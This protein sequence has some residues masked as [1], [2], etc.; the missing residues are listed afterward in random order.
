M[1]TLTQNSSTSA[2]SRWLHKVAVVLSAMVLAAT[3]QAAEVALLDQNYVLF[4]SD[5]AQAA[6]A[7]L[8]QE[9]AQEEQQVQ[10]LGQSIQQLQSRARTDADI[11]TDAEMS[12]LEAQ[13]QQRARQREQLVRQLQQVQGE[14]RSAFV[15]QFQ[16]LMAE[17][18][19]AVVEGREFDIILDKAA[20]V[21]HR[22]SLDLTDAVLEQFNAL[23]QAQ[24]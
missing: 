2:G 1:K 18:I 21:Y 7:E 22:N 3:V 5:A 16:P 4:N 17:A 11:M 14:R 20:V 12:E 9:F 24:Q 13:L 10:T 6:T 8:K 15:R 23:Y 19:E